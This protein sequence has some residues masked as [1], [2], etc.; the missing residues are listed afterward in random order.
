[1]LRKKRELTDIAKEMEQVKFKVHQY[2]KDLK[3]LR[4]KRNDLENEQGN[5]SMHTSIEETVERVQLL[6]D[7][8]DQILLA[9]KELDDCLV[10]QNALDG[11][12]I[13]IIEAIKV[14]RNE[15]L[16]QFDKDVSRIE[17]ITKQL[18][19]EVNNL[20]EQRK[21][22]VL[23][24]NSIRGIADTYLSKTKAQL[25]TASERDSHCSDQVRHIRSLL[26][27]QAGQGM[28]TIA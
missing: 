6:K 26:V 24:N 21:E 9:E 22:I 4:D 28:D 25:V 18:Q 10:E 11:E 3:V 12:V 8:N 27:K 20:A 17:K 1:M 23:K 13:S 14:I 2:T 19:R 5:E 16:E 15:A 7:V